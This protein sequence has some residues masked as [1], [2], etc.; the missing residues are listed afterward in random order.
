M[1]ETHETQSELVSRIELIE[2]MLREGRSR[3]EYW[4]WVFVLWGVA[5]MIAIGW[6]YSFVIP[7][8]AWTVT[9]VVAGILTVIIAIKKTRAK[10]KTPLGRAISAIWCGIGISIFIFCFAAAYSGHSEPHSYIAAVLLFIGAANCASSIA[11]RWL[12]QFVVALLWWISAVVTCFVPV[13]WIIPIVLI[14]AFFGFL[15]FGIYLM[16]RESRDRRRRVQAE[17]NARASHA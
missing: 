17:A 4:G 6:S 14:D 9:M 3:T 13:H 8:L 15:C 5:Y 11:L 16:I 2:A 12:G 10:T 7:Q 1:N